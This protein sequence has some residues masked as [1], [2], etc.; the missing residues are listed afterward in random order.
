LIGRYLAVTA[1]LGLSLGPHK[2]AGPAVALT[3]SGPMP[4]AAAFRFASEG[5]GEQPGDFLTRS[6]VE[7]GLKAKGFLQSDKAPRYVVEINVGAYTGP[8]EPNRAWLD[9]PAAKGAG[10]G[11]DHVCAV[12]VRFID[13]ATGAETWRAN[14]QQH[15]SVTDCATENWRLVDAVM[16]TDSAKR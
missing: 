16:G 8:A 5:V 1:L 3:S 10:F 12:R 7:K 14:A 2:P 11:S 15:A 6:V 9:A 4:G 13:A